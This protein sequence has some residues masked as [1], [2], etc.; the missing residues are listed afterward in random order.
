MNNLEFV[1]FSNDVDWDNLVKTFPTYSFLNS[2]FRF[3]HE[4]ETTNNVFRYGILKNGSYIG[5]LSCSIGKTK[6]FGKY[7]ESKHFPLLLENSKENWDQVFDFYKELSL[8][9]GCFM[10][11]LSPLYE[12][13]ELL[14]GLYMQN[15]F[16]KSPIQSIDA[17][18]SQYFDLK[19][20]DEDLRHDMTDSTRNNLNKL[21][22]N[23][24]ITVKVFSDDS[25]FKLFSDFYLQTER[26]KGFVGKSIDSLLKEFELQIQNDAFYMIVGYSKS[27][28]VSIWQCT[29]YGKYIH[30][31]QAGSDVNFREKNVRMPYLLFWESVK[32]GKQLGCEV[33]D[34]FGGMVPEGYSGKRHPWIG[35]NNFKESFGGKKVTYMH[36]RDFPLRKFRY[37]AFYVYAYIRTIL[38]G[39]TVKW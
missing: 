13:N 28:P 2:S 25:Q 34:L 3:N 1:E 4:K 10:Y 19:K 7:L 29:V 36:A 17:L 8:K 6:F 18:I 38:K 12:S 14:E 26:I 35:V 27:I 23:S 24:D 37:K 5:L 20:S 15:G 22:N 30:I 32:L 21:V 16:Y 9:N 33:L 31:Y 39:Y 11:R